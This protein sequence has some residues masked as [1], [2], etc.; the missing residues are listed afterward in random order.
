MTVL[1]P[2]SNSMRIRKMEG[3]AGVLGNLSGVFGREGGDGIVLFS[4]SH[5]RKSHVVCPCL[6]AV[7]G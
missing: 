7:E 4:Y 1:G 2:L 3:L 5:L 6:L